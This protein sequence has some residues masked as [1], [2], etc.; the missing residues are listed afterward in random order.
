[1][2]RPTKLQP[3]RVA[4]L[5]E[6]LREG[7]YYRAACAKADIGFNTFRAWMKAGQAQRHGKFREFLNS[8]KKAEGE[9]QAEIVAQWRKHCPE[10]WQA[11]RDFLARRNAAEWGQKDKRQVEHS[12]G[13]RL[14]V[15]E[16]VDADGEDEVPPEPGAEGVPRE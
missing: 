10:N 9:A 1:M 7:N 15:E 14:V 5:L 8:V 13:L 4:R 2:G 3:E 11:C 16:V 6:A 12:G